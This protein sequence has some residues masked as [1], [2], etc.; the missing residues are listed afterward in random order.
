MTKKSP[1]KYC[2]DCKAVVVVYAEQTIC[3]KCNSPRWPQGQLQ[4]Y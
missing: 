2:P 3:P 1:T 4:E